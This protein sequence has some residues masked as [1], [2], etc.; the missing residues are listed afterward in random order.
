MGYFRPGPLEDR[1]GLS[2]VAI[3]EGRLEP[4][5]VRGLVAWV[6]LELLHRFQSLSNRLRDLDSSQ[7]RGRITK[8]Q[9]QIFSQTDLVDDFLFLCSLLPRRETIQR[10]DCHDSR[11]TAFRLVLAAATVSL[12]VCF[13]TWSNPAGNSPSSSCPISVPLAKRLGRNL[14]FLLHKILQVVHIPIKLEQQWICTPRDVADYLDAGIERF[15]RN[16]VRQK[17]IW[18]R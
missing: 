11:P 5:D 16:F 2:V 4:R 12:I 1:C 15:H 6:K 13:K 7:N 8:E 3:D 14:D 18:E 17:N 9:D 10:Q